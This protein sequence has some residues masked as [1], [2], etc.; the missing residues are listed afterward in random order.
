LLGFAL[1]LD[2]FIV[3]NFTSGSLQTFPTYVWGAARRGIPGQ[4]NVF[5]TGIFILTVSLMLLFLVIQRRR[6]GRPAST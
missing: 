1:S 5:G 4:V 2:D 6:E 3:T